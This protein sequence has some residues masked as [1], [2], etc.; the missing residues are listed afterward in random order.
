MNKYK[1]NLD[2]MLKENTWSKKLT[3]ING[4]AASLND[5]VWIYESNN[6]IKSNLIFADDSKATVKRIRKSNF[7]SEWELD[8]EHKIVLSLYIN[9]ILNNGVNS[10]N[11]VSSIFLALRWFLSN[12]KK[13][14]ANMT[15]S[16][17][18]IFFN[19]STVKIQ[20]KKDCAPFFRWSISNRL[21]SPSIKIP[22]F[23]ETNDGYDQLYKNQQKKPNEEI[24]IALSAIINQVIPCNE[25]IWNFSSNTK[26]R[27]AFVCTISTLGISTPTRLAAEFIT[28]P[29]QQLQSYSD[30]NGNSIHALGTQCSKGYVG[31]FTHILSGMS[32]PVTR[33]LKYITYATEPG[34]ILARYYDDPLAKLS[35]IIPIMT[36][37][38]RYRINKLNL[39]IDKPVNMFQ[40]GLIIGFYPLNHTVTV[41]KSPHESLGKGVS[42]KLSLLSKLSDDDVITLSEKSSHQFFGCMIKKRDITKIVGKELSTITIKELQCTWINYFKHNYGTFPFMS[43]ASNQTKLDKALFTFTGNQLFSSARTSYPGAASFYSIVKGESLSNIISRDLK[44]MKNHKSIFERYGFASSFSITPHQFR[45]Y[46]SDY[47]EKKRIPHRILNLWAGRASPEHLLHY[48]HTSEEERSSEIAGIMF[49]EDVEEDKSIRLS[50]MKKYQELREQSTHIASTTSVGFCTQDLSIM[51]CMYMNDFISQCTFCKQACHVAHDTKA[52]KFLKDDLIF[53][54]RRLDKILGSSDFPSSAAKKQ[55]YRNHKQN[56]ALLSKLIEVLESKNIPKGAIVRVI[57]DKLEF[58]ISDLQLKTID[59]KK[60]TL[61]NAESDLNQVLSENTQKNHY[62]SFMDEL[63]DLI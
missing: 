11:R 36:Q 23:K 57:L 52:I 41:P 9:H 22:S 29:K 62:G 38:Q 5:Y 19:S 33:V 45:H 20:Y 6:K 60:Y 40:L 8:I 49:K 47:G 50:S 4:E 61:R 53:Q 54:T 25:K 58:R 32:A 34:R 43:F 59:T 35:Q 21:C 14:I 37:D 3:N 27:D 26:Q 12:I 7:K 30:K 44:T 2:K 55:A 24:I 31:N 16:D 46:L 13:P 56:T 42:S 17:I 39:S 10:N 1:K 48:I 15:P 51:P 18:D 28:L 63:L